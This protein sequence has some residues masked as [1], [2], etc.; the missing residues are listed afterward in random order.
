MR[1]KELVESFAW[2][3]SWFPRDECFRYLRGK[4]LIE[5]YGELLR[6]IDERAE[7]HNKKLEND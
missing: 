4:V 6:L 3:G 1:L 5:Q 7:L 2:H